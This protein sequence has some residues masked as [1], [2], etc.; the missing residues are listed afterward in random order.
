MFKII[1]LSVSL[2]TSLS[3]FA[4]TV[5]VLDADISFQA[6]HR[7]GP[8]I[9][10]SGTNGGIYSSKDNGLNWHKVT[11]PINTEQL[12]FRDIQPLDDGSVIIMSAGEGENSR[13]YR[14]EN[15][16]QDWQLQ[17]QGSKTETFYDCMHFSDSQ[18][19]WLYGD[20]D[21]QGLFILQTEDGGRH[22]QRQTLPWPAQ[23]GEGGF[24][25]SGSCL[26]RGANGDIYIGTGNTLQPRIL[27]YHNA[28]WQS[29]DSPIGG[30]EAAGIFSVQQAGESLYI[31]GGSLKNE[32]SPATAFRFNLTTQSWSQMPEV[33]LKG[34][35]YG[36]AL[37]YAKEQL[38]IL[39]ANPNGVAI[40]QQG[41]Q[42]WQMLSDN[43][44]WS[45]ACDDELGCV[46]VG[47]DGLLELFTFAQTDN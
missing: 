31:F 9:W 34:A 21:S 44:I 24:A 8:E 16:G 26:N 19:G 30:G 38:K 41:Q 32:N 14:S 23:V 20:S 12:Q 15:A 27:H 11:G 42:N 28:K 39:I 35:I 40:W 3:G 6:V 18:H 33:P 37:F 1:L 10:A 17:V 43:N 47:K 13:I 29:I 7:M 46:G 22:W 2:I 45:L 36:S 5:K 25:S 4:N